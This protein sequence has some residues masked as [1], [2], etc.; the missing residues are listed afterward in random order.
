MLGTFGQ[1]RRWAR[2][3]DPDAR[4]RATQPMR[5]A[6]AAKYLATAAR[7]P[8]GASLSPELLAERARQL[9]LADLAALR[10]KAYDAK[11][12]AASK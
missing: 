12:K 7:M 10:I 6:L 4:R 3:V 11:Q 9:R 1:R 8:D 2:T 5:D